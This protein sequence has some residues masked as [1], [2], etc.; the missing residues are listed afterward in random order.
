MGWCT[1]EAYD[2]VPW[3]LRPKKDM[4]EKSLPKEIEVELPALDLDAAEVTEEKEVKRKKSYRPRGIC[5]RR[6]IELEEYGYTPGCDGCE[7]AKLGLSHKQ[8]SSAC[9]QRIRE[10]M[11]QT[12]EGRDKVERM[13][14]RAERFRVKFKEQQDEETVHG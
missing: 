14:R 1:S 7:A 9:K 12:E 2:W 10:A 3:Q 13:D 4:G 5:I 8:H 11:L 6:D